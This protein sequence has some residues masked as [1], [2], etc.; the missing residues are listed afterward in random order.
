[1][2]KNIETNFDAVQNLDIDSVA[3]ILGDADFC[4][5]KCTEDK[6]GKYFKDGKCQCAMCWRE[7]LEEQY[8]GT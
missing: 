5:D 8:R 3:K 2:A 7:Y 6:T 4:F 1:M